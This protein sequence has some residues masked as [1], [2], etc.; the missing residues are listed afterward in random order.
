MGLVY[1]LGV[2]KMNE[3]I[4][5]QA[6][7]YIELSF[8]SGVLYKILD[9][10]KNNLTVFNVYGIVKSN[11]KYTLT[12]FYELFKHLHGDY[13]INSNGF[14]SDHFNN[15]HTKMLKKIHELGLIN[16]VQLESLKLIQ[17]LRI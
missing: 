7:R 12:S 14:T 9:N 8:I 13:I 5:D 3:I 17:Q 4:K 11:S 15:V 10:T 6:L 16:E 1:F 2:N